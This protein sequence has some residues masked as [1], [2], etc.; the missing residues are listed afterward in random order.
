V[1]AVV[2]ANCAVAVTTMTTVAEAGKR[3]CELGKESNNSNINNSNNNTWLQLLPNSTQLTD[4][5][6]TILLLLLLFYGQTGRQDDN[7]I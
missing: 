4:Y 7:R 5:H 6:L 3:K 1:C 2:V